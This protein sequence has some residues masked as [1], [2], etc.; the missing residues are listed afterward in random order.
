VG[1][2]VEVKGKRTA[3]GEKRSEVFVCL[4]YGH[5]RGNDAESLEN[6]LN[7]RVDG[8]DV[9]PKGE[10]EDASG[11]LGSD[12]VEPQEFLLGAVGGKATKGFEA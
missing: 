10:E 12:A 9:F 3:F 5:L 6:A 4:L 2:E 7:V 1:D 8:K 11:G